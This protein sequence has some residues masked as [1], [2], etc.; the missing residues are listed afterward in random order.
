[1][2]TKRHNMAVMGPATARAR[3][4]KAFAASPKALG[5][6]AEASSATPA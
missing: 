1:M 6:A 2:S 5:K 3:M 4:K